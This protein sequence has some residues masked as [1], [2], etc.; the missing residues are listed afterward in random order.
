[1]D[2]IVKFPKEVTLEKDQEYFIGVHENDVCIAKVIDYKT[3][4]NT[5]FPILRDVFDE[6]R[7]WRK[8]INYTNIK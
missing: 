4:K 3:Y 6:V 7:K 5:R 8:K 2:K 1:M